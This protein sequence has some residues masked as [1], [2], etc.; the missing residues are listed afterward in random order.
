MQNT[1][2][3]LSLLLDYPSKELKSY[4]KDIMDTVRDEKFLN[5]EQCASLQLF[6][7]YA[8]PFTLEEWQMEYVQLFD[9]STNT[10]LYL[11]DHVYGDS[12]ERGQAMV[13][14]TDMYTKSGFVPC[15]NELPDY[16]PL[17]L[18]YLSLL[19]E[20]QQTDR[21]LN[22]ISHI[23]VNMRKALDKKETPYYN[24]LKILCSLT[25]FKEVE[26]KEKEEVEI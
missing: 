18:E 4:L 1:Y 6:L 14:L 22:E 15:S 21:L 9:F 12:R 11:F 23:L 17:F 3:I 19:T 13:D 2:K 16:L 5:E 8:E 26:T 25:N 24:L 10:N 7:N 20:K